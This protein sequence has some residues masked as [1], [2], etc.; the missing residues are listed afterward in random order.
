MA[1]APGV[2]CAT[3]S[4]ARDEPLIGTASRVQRWLVVEQPGAWGR[5][6]VLESGL[7]RD[8]ARA[9]HAEARRHRVRLLLARR[10]GDRRRDGDRRVFLAH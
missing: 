9:V 6:A 8:V 5:E 7:D 2:R 10:P 3:A 4:L 1:D